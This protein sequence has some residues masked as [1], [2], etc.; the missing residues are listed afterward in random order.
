[1]SSYWPAGAECQFDWQS[2]RD[3]QYNYFNLLMD[4]AIEEAYVQ[5]VGKF[6][7]NFGLSW[8]SCESLAK[9]WANAFNENEWENFDVTKIA[10]DLD[11]ESFDAHAILGDK[12]Y[13]E[14]II[15]EK[16]STWYLKYM[17]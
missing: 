9:L 16:D 8:S 3:Q 14:K 17:E 2:K 5:S 7:E 11:L 6:Y 1:M 12:R 4:K 13:L 15:K 10:N